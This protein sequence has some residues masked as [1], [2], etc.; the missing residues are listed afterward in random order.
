MANC[1]NEKATIRACGWWPGCSKKL[2]NPVRQALFPASEL[3]PIIR[4]A[5]IGR[6]MH[7]TGEK[8]ALALKVCIPLI[9]LQQRCLQLVKKP[10]LR[11]GMEEHNRV[12]PLPSVTLTSHPSFHHERFGANPFYIMD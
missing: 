12:T 9:S 1:K 8:L 7:L 11:N 10:G 2:V 5:G 3:E 4:K 6:S